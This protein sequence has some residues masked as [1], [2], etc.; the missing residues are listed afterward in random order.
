MKM[1]AGFLWGIATQTLP[2]DQFIRDLDEVGMGR[3]FPGDMTA[4]N[5]LA[6]GIVQARKD[7]DQV[8]IGALLH[9]VQDSFS[10]AH[11]SRLPETGAVCADIGRFAQPGK[12]AQF[13]SYAGQ[14]GELH[15]KE[16]TFNALGQQTLQTSPNVVDV[17][18]SL[19]TL[20]QE[21]APWSEAEKYFDC[22]FA[23]DDAM[24]AA[25]PGPY[26]KH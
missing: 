17:S 5:L 26:A 19:L 21:K 16:D 6:T 14:S 8:A 18:R 11:A 15:D 20:W 13:Y 10:Q 25:G 22:V 1:W 2:K 12:I 3:Y 9:M 24:K 23:L 4:I 7:L